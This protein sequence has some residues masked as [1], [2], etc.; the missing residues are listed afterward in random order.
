[1]N[2]TVTSELSKNN[3]LYGTEAPFKNFG[4]SCVNN[5]G[6]EIKINNLEKP[7]K[8]PIMAVREK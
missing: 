8:A 7:I 2:E 6:E 1:M 4:P 3:M 5:R